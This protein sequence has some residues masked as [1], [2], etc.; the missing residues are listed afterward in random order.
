MPAEVARP[1]PF[2]TGPAGPV[3]WLGANFWSRVGGPRMWRRFDEAVVRQELAVLAGHGLNLTR[4]FFYWPDFHPEPFRLDEELL[5]RF[6]HFL[7]LHL[8]AGMATIPT[9]IVGHM[10][11]QNWDP[12]WRQGRDLYGD[13]W[14][15]GRQAWFI[16]EATARVAD[17]P[18]VA[19][20]LISN[21]MPIYGGGGGPMS[22]AAASGSPDHHQVTAWAELMIQAV[23]AGGGHQPVSLGDG[24]WGLEITGADN[25][26]RVRDIA[27]RVDFLGP[28]TYQMTDDPVRQHLTPAF[29]CELAHLGRPV[30]LEEFGVST[31]FA[32][33][34]AAA[35]Y[36][37]QVL[38]TTLLA[39][40]TG[41]IAW[42]N[43]DFD[44]Y[45]QDPYRHHPFE[46]H[47]GITRVDG[48]PKAPLLELRDFHR[49]L[50]RIE[51]TRTRRTATGTAIVVPS[52]LEVDYSSTEA[53]ERRTVRD[54]LLQ[55]YI[56][57]RLA[58][59]GP[60]LAR[61]VDGIPAATLL[62][63]PSTK[64][65]TA[66]G[67]RRLE[68]LAEE[69]STVLVSYFCGEVPAQRGPWHPDLDRFF[70]V[71]KRLRYGLNDPIDRATVTWT[72]QEPLGGLAPGARLSFRVGGTADGAAFLPV[73]ATR[74]R[75]YAT[76]D[77]GNPALLVREVGAGR[78]VLATYPL[79]YLAAR[80]PRVN[81]DH[82][83]RLYRAVA[84][85]A[86]VD[87]VVS[88]DD[89]RVL[90]DTR[91]HEEGRVFVWLVSQADDTVSVTPGLRDGA[92]LTELD[93]P[94]GAVPKVTL[95][96]YGVAVLQL[97]GAPTVPPPDDNKD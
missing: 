44:L 55:S 97:R 35:D 24:A 75:V 53:A 85:V 88:V 36:Y 57:A 31:D 51:V 72:I 33:E 4:S 65:L 6:R 68:R 73:E 15:V 41:W 28:H 58:D 62:I 8:D 7:D 23:R 89:P 17:H 92:Q 59:L 47:F 30:V 27:E 91:E 13:V 45:D 48:T 63:V 70:G 66:P 40:A 81:P 11:G 94:A 42:N 83:V 26:F 32:S 71:A 29:V 77:A 39:G 12:P 54:V 80:S 87:P 3:S 60:A 20:W 10:S 69:G 76:D 37:R 67:W 34:Q 9:F 25:G 96:P 78:I 46:L 43:T 95:E 1:S 5:A 61:E 50:Q 38:H 52:Y 84:R 2:L 90:T 21:E 14:M 49:T 93:D 18:A 74:A 86:G 19:A 82:V 56:S 22:Q 16:R 79:E 64:A